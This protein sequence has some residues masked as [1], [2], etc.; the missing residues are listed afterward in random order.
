MSELKVGEDAV[1]IRAHPQ[2]VVEKGLYYT[3]IG[4]MIRECGCHVVDVGVRG[5]DDVTGRRYRCAT[6]NN[7]YTDD[8][9][10]WI[11]I[12]RFAPLLTASEEAHVENEIEEALTEPVER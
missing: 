5:S 3:I 10:W 6:C 11:N 1:C 9:I 12:N 4:N 8:G 2:K 7:T